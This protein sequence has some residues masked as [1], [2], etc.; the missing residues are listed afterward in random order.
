MTG[1]DKL[2]LLNQPVGDNL[3]VYAGDYVLQAVS[4]IIFAAGGGTNIFL[5]QTASQAALSFTQTFPLTSQT[6][7]FTWLQAINQILATINYT[8]LWV[9]QLGRF[10]ASPYILPANRATDFVFDSTDA[11]YSLVA[12]DGRSTI[13]DQWNI[14]NHWVFVQN[15]YAYTPT[16][17][18]G[19]YV[20]DN[21]SNGLSSQQSLGRTVSK[22]VFL[23]AVDQPTLVALGNQQV[24]ADLSQPETFTLK[25]APLWVAGYFDLIQYIDPKIPN[26]GTRKLLAQSWELS[27]DGADM[28]WNFN[29]VASA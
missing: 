9:D 19:M 25:T 26:G 5:D 12:V 11:N 8:P 7:G 2:Y 28:T 20:V 10:R 21:L 15:N 3:V 18:A 4:A 27:M 17:G 29:S 16:V 14:P 1:Y 13:N 23:D 22:V 6:A 24:A